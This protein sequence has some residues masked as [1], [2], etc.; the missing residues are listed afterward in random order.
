MRDIATRIDAGPAAVD[1][2]R[3]AGEATDTVRALRRRA[4]GC[5]ACLPAGAAVSQIAGEVDA[6]SRARRQSRAARLDAGTILAGLIRRAGPTARSAVSRVG[7]GGNAS[8]AAKHG[9]HPATHLA[10]SGDAAH[11]TA[12]RGG[13]GGAARAAVRRV[14]LEI[15]ATP[16]AGRKARVAFDRATVPTDGAGVRRGRA[17]NPTIAAMARVARRVDTRTGAVGRPCRALQRTAALRADFAVATGETAATAMGDVRPSIDA[18]LAAQR[19][20][21]VAA[22]GTGT[23]RAFRSAV[24]GNVTRVVAGAAMNDAAPDIHAGGATPHQA[25]L[26][27]FTT[28]AR[29]A[30][31]TGSG[32]CRTRHAALAAARD[33]GP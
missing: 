3:C 23:P 21:Q 26:A 11:R 24:S 22:Q 10:P 2:P 30:E 19:F 4:L 32:R 25:R 9:P 29:F 17:K 18:G 12:R 20:A 15:D 14:A 8:A 31:C 5:R 28:D 13:T 7:V 16:V 27:L 33:R 1:G 6:A